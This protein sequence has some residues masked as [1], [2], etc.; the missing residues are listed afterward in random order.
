MSLDILSGLL[1]QRHGI[2]QSMAGSVISAIIGH[3]TQQQQGGGS[4][5]GGIGRLFSQGNNYSDDDRRD[6]IQSALSNLLGQ[7]DRG[8]LNE[9]HSLI[10]YVQQQTGIQDPQQ[11]RE[12]THH[13]LGIMNEHANNN[14][15]G[16]QS[17]FGKL[18]GL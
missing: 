10:Q 8:Q 7:R 9:D 11:A 5:D 2:D 14:P 13:A 12:Y 16:L 3:L 6:G 18:L 4:I 1:S 17:L 15:Q